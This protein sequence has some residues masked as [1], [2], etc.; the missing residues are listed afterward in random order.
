MQTGT[1][2]TKTNIP[3]RTNCVTSTEAPSTK[4]L[5]PQIV[6]DGSQPNTLTD[7][8]GCWLI[9]DGC[10]QEPQLAGKRR[11]TEGEKH[12]GALTNEDACLAR[13]AVQ[14]RACGQSYS[15]TVKAV[16][17][18]TG[19]WTVAG[20]GC[21]MGSYGC[22]SHGHS[23]EGSL[24]R[25]GYAEAQGGL[26]NET[27]CLDRAARQWVYCGSSLDNPVVS[28][29]RPTG[30]RRFAGY[31]CWIKVPHCPKDPTVPHMFFDAWGDTNRNTGFSKENCFNRAQ[32]YWDQCGSN[33]SYPVTAQFRPEGRSKTV[34]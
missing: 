21:F 9:I 17:G 31:G 34:P 10:P 7:K 27:V 32:D 3:L 5:R 18:P 26:T 29:F 28:V 19:A 24:V 23:N 8:T 20:Q 4:I 33:S 11:D 16:F 13:A 2:S 25:D 30:A 22:P 14:W 1:L 15:H 6:N 12:H